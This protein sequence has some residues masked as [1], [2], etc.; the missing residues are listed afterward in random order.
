ML[1]PSL[2]VRV[3]STGAH[4]PG[5]PISNDDLAKLVGPLPQDVLQGMQ[6]SR[7]HWLIDPAT[8]EHQTSTSAM[9]AAAA[10]QALARARVSADEVDLVV[11]S[12]ASPE[13]PLPAS[14]TYVQEELGLAQCAV[15][16]L[17]AG[18]VGAVQAFDLAR[19]YLSDGDYRT[20]LVIGAESISPALA[21]LFLGREPEKIRMRDRL[22]VYTFGDGAG[23][24]VLRGVDRSAARGEGT[25]ATGCVGALQRPGMRIVGGGTDIPAHRQQAR[26][27]MI[28][29]QLDIRATAESGPRVFTE[30]LTDM[31]NRS[32]LSLSE[33]DACVLPEGNAEYFTREMVQAG[34]TEEDFAV[35]Q[36]RVLENL[37]DVAATGSAAVPLALND[38]WQSGRLRRGDTVMLLAIEASRFLYAGLTLSWNAPA[39]DKDESGGL[40]FV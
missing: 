29:L 27:R 38:A 6:V 32:G 12:T 17:R 37:A 34:L 1:T 19:R 25:Y 10:R 11:M 23:A 4:V 18:C 22:P 26:K 39:P 21:P 2:H 30:A 28:D 14:V 7:R 31:L 40:V 20:A 35:L 13:Y 5:P 24:A 16:E 9:A 33:I 8:G 15:V 36:S 3:L